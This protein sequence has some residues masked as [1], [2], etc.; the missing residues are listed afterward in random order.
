VRCAFST[1]HLA[2][3]AHV[4]ARAR[5]ALPAEYRYDVLGRRVLVRTTRDGVCVGG[6]TDVDCTSGIERF[7]YAGDN[8][9][10]EMRG[11]GSSNAT[12]ADLDKAIGSGQEYGAV[13]YTQAGG[14]DRPLAAYKLGTGAAVIAPH[15][16][17]RG[18]FSGGTYLQGSQSTAPVSWP[19]Y[20]TT[21]WYQGKPSAGEERVYMGTVLEG[22][23]DASG[24]IYKRNRMYD[25]ATGQFTQTDPIGIAGGLNTYGF[26]AGDPVSYD[27]PYGLC[28]TWQEKLRHPVLC[29]KLALGLL[30]AHPHADLPNPINEIEGQESSVTRETTTA[31]VE[32]EIDR[33][34]RPNNPHQPPA[35]VRNARTGAAPR[36]RSQ[37]IR[38]PQGAR[39]GGMRVIGAGLAGGVAGAMIEVVTN[40][41]TAHA[42]TTP[43]RATA[44][45]E[46]MPKPIPLETDQ[47]R[48]TP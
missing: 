13:G 27:D 5:S 8:V 43:Y 47:S 46:P 16:N 12:T 17:W 36:T 1:K 37:T 15:T 18:Q 30:G 44:G 26:A 7:V 34:S 22:Q 25:P 41:S 38:T 48:R 11:P 35:H 9:L 29:A 6:G 31:D 3:A 39:G 42:A 14:V 19:G 23:R 20:S 28:A 10:W 4:S 24:Q 21:A 2:R 45:D 33:R 40:P 32:R